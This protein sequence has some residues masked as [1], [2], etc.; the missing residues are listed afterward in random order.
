MLKTRK[1]PNVMTDKRAEEL[2]AEVAERK[3]EMAQRE[4]AAERAPIE[5]RE[6]SE[7][8]WRSY[9]GEVNQMPHRMW[10]AWVEAGHP[11]LLAGS[12]VLS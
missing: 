7:T 10:Q 4:I 9:T 11:P 8:D 12:E 3:R 5:L 1:D 2:R 6:S